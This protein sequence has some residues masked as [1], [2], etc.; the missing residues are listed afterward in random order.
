MAT[1][2]IKNTPSIIERG[3]SGDWTYQKWSDG[4]AEC[5]Y[6]SIG[7]KTGVQKSILGDS[8][9]E[10]DYG[11]VSYPLAFNGIPTA[12]VTGNVGTNYTNVVYARTTVTGISISLAGASGTN[13]CRLS[14]YARGVF[15]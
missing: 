10:Y 14:I 15:A 3:T 13:E 9:Y 7:N 12:L 1:S 8:V 11:V 6:L 2:K 5:W 4:T